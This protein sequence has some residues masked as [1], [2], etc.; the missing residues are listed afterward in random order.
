G[1]GPAQVRDPH[2]L[3]F[4]QVP[5]RD[6]PCPPA[7]SRGDHGRIMQLPAVPG[8]D[9]AAVSPAFPGP[10]VDP[11]D[12]AC[13]GVIKALRD[14]PGELLTFLDLR[15]RTWSPPPHRN[16]RTHRVLRRPLETAGEQWGQLGLTR[17]VGPAPRP[18]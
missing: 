17:P 9:R 4:R 2:P 14:Q 16:P 10:P 7:R 11:D 12:P 13:L 15:Q 18:N 1:P 5:V 6:L 8:R 3:I